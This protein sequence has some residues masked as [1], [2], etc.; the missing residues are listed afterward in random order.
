MLPL[1]KLDVSAQELDK[2]SELQIDKSGD[3]SGLDLSST[4]QRSRTELTK[5]KATAAAVKVE[6]DFTEPR[7]AMDP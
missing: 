2:S 7:T 6:P 3:R 4:H 1:G 5:M